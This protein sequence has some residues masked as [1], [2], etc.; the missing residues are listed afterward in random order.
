[1]AAA[2]VVQQMVPAVAAG[3]LFTADPVT[4]RRDHVV[5][6]AAPGLGDALV[7]GRVTPQRWIVD[8]RTRAIL[9]AP[10]AAGTA[11]L[12]P[13][14]LGELV[15]LGLRAAELFGEPQDLE[16]AVARG[17]CWL[18]QSRPITSL[19]P[20]PP[21]AP[22]PGVD[23]RVYMPLNL[24]AQG[25]TEPFTPAGTAFFLGMGRATL[26]PRIARRRVRIHPP[27]M[28]VVADRIYYDVTPLL[29]SPRLAARLAKQLQLK[30]PTAGAALRE[31]LDRNAG[32]LPRQRRVAVPVGIA[33]WLVGQLPATIAAVA[34]PG[35]ARR[36]M[37]V[38]A[39]AE[40]ARLRHEAAALAAPRAQAEFLSG[41]LPVRTFD[42][43]MAQLPPLYA[44]LLAIP[45]AERLT[46]RWLGS[47]AGVEPATPMA[48]ARPD[49][50]DGPEPGAG[51]PSLR[52]RRR[53]ALVD[54][55]AR[56][57]VPGA[58][59]APRAGPGDRPRPAPLHRRPRLRCR[60]AAWLPGGRR[61]P[62]G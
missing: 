21:S 62:R 29:S 34:A 27:R 14:W 51:G 35:R 25:M 22:P 53:G 59:R 42:L 23:L 46:E 10:D 24:V 12:D 57:G 19:F 44:G 15:G 26:R 49:R 30:D 7:S 9:A 20:L 33:A 38:R 1:V 36:R 50:R 41:P 37:L 54:Q 52:D 11:V 55:S 17:R 28:S 40:L 16:W 47:S 45:L 56:A 4:G 6:E 5:V 61:D 60:A 43:V 13:E 39:E 8:A 3:V 2:V 18:L 31:W 58:V 48:A 32:R